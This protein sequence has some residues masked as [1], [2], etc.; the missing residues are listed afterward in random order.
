M[1]LSMYEEDRQNIHFTLY[2]IGFLHIHSIFH[3]LFLFSHI[4]AVQNAVSVINNIY[5]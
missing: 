2:K 4:H 1:L 5:I 3:I